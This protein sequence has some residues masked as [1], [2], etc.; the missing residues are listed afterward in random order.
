MSNKF[1]H[2]IVLVLC[3]IGYT[4][5]SFILI[6]AIQM[7]LDLPKSLLSGFCGLC[8]LLFELLLYWVLYIPIVRSCRLHVDITKPLLKL[9]TGAIL[10]FSIF[11]IF[12]AWSSFMVIQE[13]SELNTYFV[14][15]GEYTTNELILLENIPICFTEGYLTDKYADFKIKD[16][17]TDTEIFSITKKEMIKDYENLRKELHTKVTIKSIFTII[18]SLLVGALLTARTRA[19]SILVLRKT[20]APHVD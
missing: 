12:N 10:A 4:L 1:R 16:I 20:G 6:T 17:D 5:Y 13:Y 2:A 8:L 7:L 14:E 19:Q 11:I 9:N 15:S 3:S 18:L